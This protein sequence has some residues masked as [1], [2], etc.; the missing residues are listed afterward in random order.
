MIVHLG[1]EMHTWILY[2]GECVIA[3]LFVFLHMNLYHLGT[4]PQMM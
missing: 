4:C 3:I 2:L 1:C